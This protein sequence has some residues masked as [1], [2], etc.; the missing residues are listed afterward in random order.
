M[1]KCTQSILQLPS[2]FSHLEFGHYVMSP[3]YL[4]VLFD[5]WVYSSWRNAWFTVGTCYASAPGVWTVFF[6]KLDSYPEVDSRPALL[7]PRSLEKCAQFRFFL[8]SCYTWKS[9]HYFHEPRVFCSLCSLFQFC[10]RRVFLLPGDP[11]PIKSQRLL[12]HS[13]GTRLKQQQ[14]QQQQQL[15]L[16]LLL[17]LLLLQLL[18]LQQQQ[19]LVLQLLLQLQQLLQLQLLQIQQVL[20]LQQLQLG[21]LWLVTGS[22]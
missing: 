13:C 12:H 3:L 19:L 7:E 2:L 14:Q 11:P 16:L 17:Q 18:Q 4:A 5:V 9:G 15:L 20:L 8:L 10:V 1:E 6:V 21:I 22:G